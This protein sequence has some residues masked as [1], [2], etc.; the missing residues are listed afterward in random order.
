MFKIHI[1]LIVLYYKKDVTFEKCIG[2]MNK[3]S[4]ILLSRDNILTLGIYSCSLNLCFALLIT[5]VFSGYAHANRINER[6]QC[7][8]SRYNCVDC[9]QNLWTAPWSCHQWCLLDS[10]AAVSDWGPQ[11]RTQSGF[12]CVLGKGIFPGEIRILAKP[13][14]ARKYEVW[15]RNGFASL[16]GFF[17]LAS[18]F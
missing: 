6:P 9:G 2:Q 14:L 18:P 15:E 11:C 16:E 8:C 1:Y 17:W 3:S 5:I 7:S 10:P 13:L 12:K 4:L